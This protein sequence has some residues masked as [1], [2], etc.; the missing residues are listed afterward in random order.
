[1]YTH[2]PVFEE[3]PGSFF[4]LKS[5][6]KS[7]AWLVVH[8]PFLVCIINTGNSKGSKNLLAFVKVNECKNPSSTVFLNFLLLFYAHLF[9][10]ILFTE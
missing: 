1:M 2:S 5:S 6:V 7:S 8:K 3:E 4:E 9:D 10:S